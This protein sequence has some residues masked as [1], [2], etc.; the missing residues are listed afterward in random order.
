MPL[1]T[2]RPVYQA[3]LESEIIRLTG[4]IQDELLVELA[5]VSEAAAQAEVSY[6]VGNAKAFLSA[7][8]SVQARNAAAVVATENEL[9]QRLVTERQVVTAREKLRAYEASL[10]SLRTLL[11]GLRDQVR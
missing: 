9:F 10:D 7:T 11:V 3:E 4:A 2:D 5:Q 1:P 8:G 6:K